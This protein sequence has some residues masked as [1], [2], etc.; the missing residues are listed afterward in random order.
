M[1]SM[2]RRPVHDPRT[3][4][5]IDGVDLLDADEVAAVV[6]AAAEAAPAWAAE[7]AERRCAY[8]Q[9]LADALAA[10]SAEVAERFSREHG[11]TPTEAAG[12]LTR[13]VETLRWS[14][15]AARRLTESFALPNRGGLRRDVEVEPAGPVL[16]I[17]PWN[18]PA[19]ILARKVGPALAMGCPVIVKAAEET[20]AVATAFA[21]AAAEAGLPPGVLRIVFAAPAQVEA[22]IRRP[23]V[24]HVTFTG[25]TRV[26]R[27]VAAAA[28]EGPT[29]CTLELGG[30]APAVVTADADLDRAVPAIAA[31]AFGSA[32][33]SCGAPSRLLV[34][35]SRYEE[36]VDRLVDG[37]PGL[38]LAGEA[39][40]ERQWV[41]GPV[42]NPVRRA[43][44]HA[45]VTDAV[46]RGGRLRTGGTVDGLPGCYYPPT[47]LT[48]VPRGARVLGTEPFGPVVVVSPY[49]TDDEAVARANES[50]YALSAY[51][52]GQGEHARDLARRLNAGSVTVNGVPG[53][54]P[55]A[56]L[57]GRLASGYGYEGGTAGLMQ[58]GRFKIVQEDMP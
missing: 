58:F 44:V 41:I 13:A 51:V 15:G 57:G 9:R 31:T 50:E 39:G 54:A 22:L 4:A 6:T 45:L 10:R 33:Q 56:P 55:D 28:A 40:T 11:K 43:A 19:V 46:N 21:E 5:V 7:P 25:S 32:G 17:T 23:E 48:D 3:G 26:G 29:P 49:D 12:E 52:F 16:A 53:A 18:F 2:S 38:D 20:P 36:F 37:L 34:H 27:L 47:V 14:A 24:R 8:V 42:Q 35:R 30:H 1:N